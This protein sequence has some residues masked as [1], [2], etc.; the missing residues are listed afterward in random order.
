[1]FPFW[2]HFM[3][4]F[5]KHIYVSILETLSWSNLD[6]FIIVNMADKNHRKSKKIKLTIPNTEKIADDVKK[7]QVAVKYDSDTSYFIIKE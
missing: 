3:F 4:P 2:K 5:W 1:M 6:Q 7:I